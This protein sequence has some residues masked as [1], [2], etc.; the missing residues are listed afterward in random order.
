VA[1]AGLTACELDDAVVPVAAAGV[2]VHAVMRPDLPQQFV[3][4]E[5]TLDGAIDPDRRV[6]P[7]PPGG[8]QAPIEGAVVTVTNL[9]FSADPCGAPVRFDRTPIGTTSALYKNPGVYWSPPGCPTMRPGD[10][11]ELRVEAPNL[12]IVTG[13]TRVPGL[14]G[15]TLGVAGQAVAPGDTVVL[16]RDR[17]ALDVAA[18][19]EFQRSLQIV[20]YRT[21]M[22]PPGADARLNDRALSLLLFVD[23]TSVSLPGTLLH[24]F[25]RGTGEAAFRGGRRYELGVGVAD[26][27]Y[28]DFVRSANNAITGRGFANRLQGGLGVFG[29]MV[30]APFMVDALADADDPLEGV[31]AFS[32]TVEG[33]TVD[34]QL[35]AFLSPDAEA[36]FVSGFLMGQ[37]FVRDSDG[38]SRPRNVDGQSVDGVIGGDTLRVDIP[39][40]QHFERSSILTRVMMR[41]LR[42]PDGSYNVAVAESTVTGVYVLGQLTARRP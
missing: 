16:N 10:R 4:V 14:T 27:N 8:L 36:G 6:Q 9:D 41:G 34:L 21:G 23:S 19:A 28:Y 31:Y 22:A 7:V 3:L 1:W 29:S 13:V 39:T 5:Q 40:L 30:V 33:V 15:A 12:G 26:S 24:A 20:A 42:G 25:A 11:L 2:V 17:Q 37:W 38:V 35:E 32:G 18:V